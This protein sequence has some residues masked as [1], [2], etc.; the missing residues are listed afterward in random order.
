MATVPYAPQVRPYPC[1]REDRA[2]LA[3]LCPDRRA[4]VRGGSVVRIAMVR[5]GDADPSRI[6]N[7]APP[8]RAPLLAGGPTTSPCVA[9]CLTHGALWTGHAPALLPVVVV[10]GPFSPPPLLP[11]L[12]GAGGLDR[13]AGTGTWTGT[14]SGGMGVGVVDARSTP[15]F[16]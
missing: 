13:G 4:R 5:V 10:V 7:C 3:A 1:A 14:L 15:L 12:A 2:S 16:S 11:P 9:H 8:P 6:L